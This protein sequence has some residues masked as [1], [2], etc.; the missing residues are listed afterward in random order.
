[1]TVRERLG[2]SQKEVAERLGVS[3]SLVSKWEKGERKPDDGQF[4]EL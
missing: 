2:K 3:P 4:W 1:M